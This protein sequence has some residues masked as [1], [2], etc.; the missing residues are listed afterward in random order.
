MACMRCAANRVWSG[1]SRVMPAL[2]RKIPFARVKPVL[3][4]FVMPAVIVA[5]VIVAFQKPVTLWPM[6]VA[7]LVAAYR[8]GYSEH[9]HEESREE[10][11]QA[12]E[13]P[14]GHGAHQQSEAERPE[15]V[16]VPVTFEE[17]R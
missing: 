13:D 7:W 15:G 5:A 14:E 8:L 16:A 9:T 17:G 11:A 12:A 4:N 2:R 6:T 3:R 1:S 10:T